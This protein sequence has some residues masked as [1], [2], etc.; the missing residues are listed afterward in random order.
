MDA[1]AAGGFRAL[2]WKLLP[3]S[4]SLAVAVSLQH[5]QVELAVLVGHIC[6]LSQA[7]ALARARRAGGER[8]EAA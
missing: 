7:V 2:G 6:A 1:A 4:P 5:A 8:G 3:L